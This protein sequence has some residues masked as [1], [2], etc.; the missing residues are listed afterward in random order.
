MRRILLIVPI[1][2]LAL[3]ACSPPS[4]SIP[5]GGTQ[6]SGSSG[7]SGSGACVDIKPSPNYLINLSEQD[8]VAAINNARKQE[9]L[10]ALRLPA[11]FY[12]LSSV[13]QQFSL[14]NLERTDRGLHALQLD[15]TLSQM[16][17]AYSKQ[18]LDLNFFSHTSPIGGSFEERFNDN[19][20]IHGHFKVAAE[21]LAGDPVAGIG[22]MYNYMYNDAGEACGHR[23]NILN[24]DLTAV[25]IGVVSGSQYGSLSAQEFLGSAPWDRYKGGTPDVTPPT[26]T[27]QVSKNTQ[28]GTANCRAFAQDDR[29]VVR[30]TWFVDSVGNN[31]QVGASLTLKLSSLSPGKHVL[32]AYAVDG[33]QN[34]GV[35]QAEIIV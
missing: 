31:A 32:F 20:V 27:I 16:A 8:A 18:M 2:L 29:Q 30:I 26:I 21:N 7:G 34:Y 24:A 6:T 9:H 1:L 14:I 25:G 12:D 28:Q 13:Q 5:T 35:A 17:L 11:H 3:S 10:A 33:D 23:H 19:P 22:P 15:P 4:V